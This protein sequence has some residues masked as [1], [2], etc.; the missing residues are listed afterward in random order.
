MPFDAE[1]VEMLQSLAATAAVAL[2]NAQMVQEINRLN[3]AVEQANDIIFHLDRDGCVLNI[4]QAGERITGLPKNQMIGQ[5]FMSFCADEALPV[6]QAMFKNN[7]RGKADETRHEMTVM[8]IS[9]NR[10]V[11]EVDTWAIREQ[12]IFSGIYGVARDISIR[13]KAELELKES[14]EKFRQLAENIH[15]VFWVTDTQKHTMLYISPAYEGVWGRSV[16]S[17]YASPKSWL[18]AIHPEDRERILDAAM[19]KQTIGTYDEEYRIVR[20][21][22]TVRWIRDR[23][24][25]IRNETGLVY[26]VTGIAEDITH[27]V[28]AEQEKKK[29]RVK[30]EHTQRLESLG[31]LAGGIAH[32]FNNIL[33]TILGNAA[34]AERK[35]KA[36]HRE[37]LPRYLSNI[38]ASSEK[39]AELCKQMLAYSGK[40]Q[41]VI[42]PLNLTSMV[43]EI[44]QLLEVSIVKNITLK[45]QLAEALPT[46]DADAAQLQQVI[47]NLVINA[48]DAIGDTSGQI[49]LSTG[50]MQADQQYLAQ[51][52]LHEDLPAGDY[53]FLEVSDT[54][55]GMD[56]RTQQRIFEPFFTTKP[57]GHGLGMSAVLGIVHGHHGALRL[58]SE[59]GLGTIFKLLLPVSDQA[60]EADLPVIKQS[61]TWQASGTILIVDDEETIRETAAMMLEDAGFETLTAVDGLDGVEVYRQHQHEIVA[62]LLDMT[63]PKMDGQSCFT[64]LK[65]INKDVKVVLSSG[66]NEQEATSRFAG[67][68]LGGFI[69]KPYHP[70]ALQDKIRE[71]I[72]HECE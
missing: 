66:Y 35:A 70:D 3:L 65:Q 31:V 13:K 15:E 43:S 44:S 8:D 36:N 45:Y 38:V 27:R 69:Q 39:A 42:K 11:V 24:F 4:N 63:M 53:V 71:V 51:T 30:A 49:S 56:A 21:D 32:D 19:Q 28:V 33:T 34:M 57:T 60:V 58:H 23:A 59:P 37:G 46:V 72:S 7:I 6:A 29:L 54:G 55:S 17:L 64:E 9:G 22:G 47:M 12:G 41:F 67:Q 20:P 10:C 68:R 40:G 61:E 18:E 48:S 62:V 2:E 14:E 50:V 5:P 26:R 52:C 1:D 16:D 25:P